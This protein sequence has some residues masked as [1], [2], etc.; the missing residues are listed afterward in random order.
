M[1]SEWDAGGSDGSVSYKIAELEGRLAKAC[2][3]CSLRMGAF[4]I[5]VWSKNWREEN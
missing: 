1:K 3:S 2:V 4:R 5:V